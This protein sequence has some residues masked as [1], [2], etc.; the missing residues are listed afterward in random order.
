MRTAVVEFVAYVV[1]ELNATICFCVPQNVKSSVRGNFVDP[2]DAVERAGAANLGSNVDQT[3]NATTWHVFLIALISYA[4]TTAVT[5]RA[6][7]ACSE[8]FVP[9]VNAS[10]DLAAAFQKGLEIA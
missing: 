10:R 2:T 5:G 7:N 1:R 9:R 3:A 4:E 6:V 8:T